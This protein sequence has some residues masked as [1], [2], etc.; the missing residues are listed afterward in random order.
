MNFDI[1]GDI[2]RLTE[3]YLWSILYVVR[4]P[5]VI[6]KFKNQP[7]KSKNPEIEQKAYNT[8]FNV[9]KFYFSF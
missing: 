2:D 6:F 7:Q 5:C 8:N 4:F 1:L 9:V 3:M